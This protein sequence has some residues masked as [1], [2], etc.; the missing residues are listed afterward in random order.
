LENKLAE[1]QLDL[2]KS[3]EFEL[4]FYSELPKNEH[5]EPIRKITQLE[6]LTE[7]KLEIAKIGNF[8][9]ENMS[10]YEARRIKI[11]NYRNLL[12]QRILEL[13]NEDTEFEYIDQLE[14]IF[15]NAYETAKN[16]E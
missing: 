1:F 7:L 6:T 15:E 2:I 4:S 14:Q 16:K 5:T 9:I 10:I 13:T 8:D 12:K 3:S 11:I